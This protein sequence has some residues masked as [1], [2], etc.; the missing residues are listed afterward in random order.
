MFTPRDS[1]TT[2]SLKGKLLSSGDGRAAA[3]CGAPVKLAVRADAHPPVQKMTA[4]I[5]RALISPYHNHQIL[6]S[7][8]HRTISRC[9]PH[10]SDKRSS[11]MR[12]SS[13]SAY[14]GEPALPESETGSGLHGVQISPAVGKLAHRGL[15]IWVDGDLIFRRVTNG[16]C[17]ERNSGSFAQGAELFFVWFIACLFLDFDLRVPHF[18][19]EVASTQEP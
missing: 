6:W 16:I 15:G 2:G 11:V 14:Q 13:T 1:S 3:R 7:C 4:V 17:E 19:R 9:P 10:I 5:R 18:G 12:D 8:R